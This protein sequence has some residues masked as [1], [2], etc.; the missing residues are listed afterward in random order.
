[1]DRRTALIGLAATVGGGITSRLGG[2]LPV[3]LFGGAANVDA[4]SV[5]RIAGT[6][7]IQSVSIRPAPLGAGGFV[8]GVD[9]STDGK[10]FVCR[11][12]VCNAYVRDIDDAAWRPLFSP[13]SMLPADFDPLPD[14][15]GKADGQ[16][17]AGVRIAPSDK[18][19]IY[20]SYYGYVWR[21][22]DGGKTVR[23]TALPQKMMPSNADVQRN[24]NRPIDVHPTDP[25]QVLVGTWGEG[26]WYSRDGGK[27]WA[28]LDLPPALPLAP[29]SPGV[30]TV[31]FSR[32]PDTVYV[33]VGGVGLFISTT[34]AG[35]R[36]TR[37]PDGPTRCSSL[38]PSPDG[39]VFLCEA[40]GGDA[41]KLWRYHPDAG[42]RATR[43]EHEMATVAV[44]P[45]DPKRVFASG[46]YGYVQVSEDGGLTFVPRKLD[47][48]KVKGEVSWI[49][50]LQ[51]LVV[52][53]VVW[54]V[55]GGDTIW[56]ANGVGIL[57]A[58][59]AARSLTDWSAGIEE[60]IAISGLSVPG[61]STILTAWD[62][63]LWRIK[64]EK[65]YVNFPT[66]P[67]DAGRTPLV[68]PITH[69][70]FVDYAGDDPRYLVGV[71]TPGR[72]FDVPYAPGFSTDGGE[73]W[74]IFPGTP[75]KGWGYGGC[76]A[77][78]TRQNIVVLPS[79]NGFGA[80]TLDGGKS[81][82]TIRLDGK[83]ETSHFANAYYVVRKNIAADKTRKGVFALVYTTMQPEPDPYGNPLGGLWLTTD[84]GK[85]WTQMLKGIV[86]KGPHAPKATPQDQDA[87]Q[88]WR[89][90]LDYVPDHKGELVYTSY[91]DYGDDRLWWSRDDGASWAE[92]HGSIRAVVSFGFGKPAPGQS[93]PVVFFYGKVDGVE[94]THASFDWFATK[95]VLITRHAS[96]Q[97]A[98][99][100]WVTGDANR[101][102]RVWLGTGGAGWL[103]ADVEL[104]PTAPA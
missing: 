104:K 82:E 88:F 48:D 34:G 31:L 56:Y 59:I 79:N 64:D 24:F 42:W 9:Q 69:G 100:A 99:I 62:K 73:T 5:Y 66:Y 3:S 30:S 54:D 33:F 55:G 36:F 7:P 4:A 92:L 65:S 2:I 68:D 87:R 90:Q 51:T 40:S 57:K 96:P 91:A 103:I 43:P 76:I 23:R 89:C 67:T 98:N 44:H 77:A 86:N 58:D 83:T 19:V 21:S 61:G 75:P 37:V 78:S 101:F 26:V 95:P 70:T 49:G 63:P 97:L 60:L 38:A 93:R 27:A 12:D 50:H 25:N 28:A 41:G 16:G 72:M 29:N 53:E 22:G 102:G 32:R 71:V 11:T 6:G 10:R 46:G 74:T 52:A 1:M 81:W 47:Y 94:G 14:L 18:D 80:Y 85:S 13:S 17:V 8:T 45:T 35:G 84:G 20:A 39:A 15:K